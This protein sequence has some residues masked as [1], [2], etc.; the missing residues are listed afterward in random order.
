M[1]L[2]KYQ[3]IVHFA[4]REYAMAPEKLGLV[5]LHKILWYSEVRAIQRLGRPISGER[6]IRHK[7]GPFATQLDETLKGL[8]KTGLLNIQPPSEEFEATALVGKGSPNRDALSDEEWRLV[9]QVT[10]WV[11][12]DHSASTIS[13]RTHD[14]VWEAVE[15]FG[16]IPPMLAAI[17]VIPTPDAVKDAVRAQ[18]LS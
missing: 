1:D 14:D 4:T 2:S 9:E 6:F 7:R 11:A 15:M 3:A 18:Y 8:Q 5:K 17:R 16:E 13:E 10:R 12:E